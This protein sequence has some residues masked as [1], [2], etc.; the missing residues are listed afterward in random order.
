VAHHN[1]T[2]EF[3]DAV[4][5]VF[6]IPPGRG[7]WVARAILTRAVTHIADVTKDREYSATPI[8]EVGFRTS[9]AVPM[10][11]EGQPI[12]AISVSRMEPRPFTHKQVKLL[13]TFADQAVIAVENVRLFQELKARNRELTEAL[14]Q[15]TA[16]ADI[17]R[18]ISSSPTD[19]QPVMDAVAA[20]AARLCEAEDAYI[21]RV[22]GESF[23]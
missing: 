6:P 4:R 10:L 5:R 16:T 23:D 13:E 15:Q 2:P 7:T 18:V 8:V 19:L 3:L 14:D 21:Y 1:W 9:L 17:L 22:D 12:G 20:N 11:R